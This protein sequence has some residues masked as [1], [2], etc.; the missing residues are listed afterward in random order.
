MCR[1]PQSSSVTVSTMI[2]R[3]CGCVI[4][5]SSTRR[6]YTRIQKANRTVLA[7]AILRDVRRAS[8]FKAQEKQV[9][10]VSR[11]PLPPP[12]WCARQFEEMPFLELAKSCS[13]TA[14][15]T[16]DRRT[17]R[18]D[19]M[20]EPVGLN[21]RLKTIT[22]A[23]LT[24]GMHRPRTNILHMETKSVRAM[25]V[26]GNGRIID[27]IPGHGECRITPAFRLLHLVRRR[28]IFTIH[29]RITRTNTLI[30]LT[31]TILAIMDVNHLALKR[32]CQHMYIHTSTMNI[33]DV[34]HGS[35]RMW[36]RNGMS[37]DGAQFTTEKDMLGMD[38]DGMDIT[39]LD[40]NMHIM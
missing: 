21:S 14:R 39:R 37:L 7:C 2:W 12:S 6:Y 10:Q 23:T 20:A 34:G 8:S 31:T 13:T 29:T 27:S 30:G 11:T 16:T 40:T 32:R 24:N 3:R 35:G 17:T 19:Y 36:M 38:M 26:F 25:N 5:P 22:H 18:G 1:I 28:S 15:K 9:T 4:L 33:L